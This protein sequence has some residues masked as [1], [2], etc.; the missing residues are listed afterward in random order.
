VLEPPDE[1][2]SDEVD[3]ERDQQRQED[4]CDETAVALL[5]GGEPFQFLAKDPASLDR[6]PDGIRLRAGPPRLRYD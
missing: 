3:G 1:H 2:R 4:P 5:P 6:L